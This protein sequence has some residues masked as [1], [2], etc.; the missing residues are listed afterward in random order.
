MCF[1]C[2]RLVFGRKKCD[3]FLESNIT[4]KQSC[5][6]KLLSKRLFSVVGRTE[7][8]YMWVDRDEE[9]GRSRGIRISLLF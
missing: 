4:E 7:F 8:G 2:M 9:V 6:P 3:A 5:L 1:K